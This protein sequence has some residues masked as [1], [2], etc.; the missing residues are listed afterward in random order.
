MLEIFLFAYA[1]IVALVISGVLT[2]NAGTRNVPFLPSMRTTNAPLLGSIAGII[3]LPFLA[4]S[5][6]LSDAT[7]SATEAIFTKPSVTLLFVLASLVVAT[8]FA[9]AGWLIGV[10]T[11]ASATP[12]FTSF[13]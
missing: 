7:L 5:F 2:Y 11:R 13:D 8:I 12:P 10:A 9:S 4:S 1:P 6:L 3:V